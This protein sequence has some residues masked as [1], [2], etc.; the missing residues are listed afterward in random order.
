MIRVNQAFT[1]YRC[2]DSLMGK[3]LSS[4]LKFEPYPDRFLALAYCK[5]FK[6]EGW[7][8]FCRFFFVCF[9]LKYKLHDKLKF[10]DFFL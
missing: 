7:T 3:G 10:N 8:Y 4:S 5:W 9:T 1:R 6:E 2:I